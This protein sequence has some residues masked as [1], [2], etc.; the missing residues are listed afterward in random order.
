MTTT[1]PAALPANPRFSSGPCAKPPTWSLEA[2]SDAP[3]GRSHR[4]AIGKKKLKEAI[5]LTR[6]VLGVP[7]DYRIGIVPASDTG[8]VE[9][10]LWSLLGA[11]PVEMLAWESFGEGWVTDVVKQLKLDAEIKK[12]P[13]G[14]IVDF[15][16]VDFDKDVVFTWNGTTS[17]VRL[18]S[19]DAIPADRAGLTICDATS[20]AFAQ[21]L[22]WDKLDVVTFSWQKVLGGEGGHGVLILSPRAVERLESYTP[23]W[24]LPKIFRLTS[25]GK[26]IEGIFVGETI[27]TPSMLC[28]EDYIFA[29]NWA[30]SV[31]GFTGLQA[32]A[33]ANS[34]AIFDFCATRDWID[35]LAED[36]AT[37]SNTSVCLKFTNPAIKDGAAFAKGVAKRL[38]AEGAALDAASYRDAPAGLRVWC[39]ATVETADV[40][41]ML[42]WLEWAYQAELAAQA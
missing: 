27:N 12:A 18:P 17:G 29:L 39:G 15:A 33:D 7:A 3:V 42:P 23:A 6:E 13:Y 11:R 25:K 22:A 1:K 40:A 37:R 9:M 4:A 14:Q 38:E 34:Q 32:R 19:G 30:K 41:A 8:A 20:A 10:A 5:D 35:N 24:P 26:L 16:T 2:L 21:D 31:G 28:V 36:A